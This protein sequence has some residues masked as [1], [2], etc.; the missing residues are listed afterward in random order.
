MRTE[1]RRYE[2][3]DRQAVLDLAPRL[4]EGVAAWRSPDRV[5]AAVT[6]WVVDA[7][8]HSTDPGRFVYVADIDGAVAGFVSGEERTHWSGEPELY[9]GEL[10]VSMQYKGRGIGRALIEAV[11]EHAKHLGLATITLDTGAANTPARAFYRRLGF[12]EEDVKL[13]K[14]LG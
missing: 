9:V 5:R 1:V 13:T 8:E 3:R 4:S 10:A 6:G 12:D 11:T 7:L 14:V 2:T